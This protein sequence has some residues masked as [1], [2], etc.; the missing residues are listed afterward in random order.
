M[1]SE[2]IMNCAICETRRP[3]RYCPGVR[4]EICA[5]CCGTAREVTVDCPL[6]CPYLRGS[7]QAREAA[8]TRSGA[9]S[10]PG[11]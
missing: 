11:R 3:R 5:I 2:A 6:D 10:E 1:S 8:R 9:V 4:G 7:P